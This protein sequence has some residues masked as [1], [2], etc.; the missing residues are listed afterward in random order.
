M[1]KSKQ[2][3]KVRKALYNAPLH[4]RRKMISSHLSDELIWKYDT[5]SVPVRKGDTV[6]II[7]G[8][9][10]GHV[11]KV[12]KIDTKKRKIL[13]EGATIAKADGTR[14]PRLIDPS[15]VI[16]TKLDLT[17]PRRKAKIE[18]LGGGK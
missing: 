13:I 14:I 12:V 18:S 8:A 15:N 7:R 16:I 10:Q 4:K 11:E 2:P 6:K 3:R 5:R 17:D 9:L 1:T